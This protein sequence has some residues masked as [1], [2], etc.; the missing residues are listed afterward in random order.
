[1]NTTI[2]SISESPRAAGQIW[3]GT[4]DGNVQLT[5]D[6]GAQLDQ[7]ARPISECPQG[8]WISWVEASRFSSRG[9]LCDRRPS[10][11]WR[12]AAL[13]LPHDRLRPD[14]A[15]AGRARDAGRSRLRPCHQGRPAQPQHPVPRHRVRPVHVAERRPSWAQFKPN[16][17]PDGV[18]VRDIA[19]QER[20]DDLVLATH[21]RGIWVIDDISPLRALSAPALASNAAR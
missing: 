8:N 17:F 2:Y 21:G 14:V 5:R 3:V 19:L 20:E 18:A 9:R 12:H 15:A 1:M 13:S 7:P 6:G 16:N 4:D 11:L 10:R